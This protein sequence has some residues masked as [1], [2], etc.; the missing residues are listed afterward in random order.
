MFNFFLAVLAIEA[1]VSLLGRMGV[2]A[3]SAVGAFCFALAATLD[4]ADAVIAAVL[5]WLLVHLFRQLYYGD[6]WP[7]DRMRNGLESVL[8]R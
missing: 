1:I 6:R 5:A 4:I 7:F 3:W 2:S 8:D